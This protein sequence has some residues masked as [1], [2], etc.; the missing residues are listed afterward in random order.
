MSIATV[1]TRGY[2]SFGTIPLVVTGGYSQG[3]SAPTSPV[4]VPVGGVKRKPRVIRLRDEKDREKLADFIKSELLRQFPELKGPVEQ[5]FQAQAQIRIKPEDVAKAM[6]LERAENTRK[7]ITE[8]NN[9]IIAVI[10]AS[11]DDD[12]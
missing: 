10:L 4:V 1:V 7:R 12:S 6:E 3:A 11:Y 5:P 8:T 9:A 2:G